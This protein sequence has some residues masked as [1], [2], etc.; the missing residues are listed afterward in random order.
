MKALG[1]QSLLQNAIQKVIEGIKEWLNCF[2]AWRVTHPQ[3]WEYFCS[4]HGKECQNVESLK[5]LG[6]GYSTHYS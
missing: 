3:E 1:D 6:G 2:T 5:Y 4:Y